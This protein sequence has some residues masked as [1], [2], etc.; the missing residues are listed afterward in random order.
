MAKHRSSEAMKQEGRDGNGEV[1]DSALIRSVFLYALCASS[2]L[3]VST[4][5]R[6]EA[7]FPVSFISSNFIWLLLPA[8][9]ALELSHGAFHLFARG[10]GS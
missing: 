7:R 2:T 8:S 4:A 6:A 1:K 10:I 3:Y 5:W 9:E